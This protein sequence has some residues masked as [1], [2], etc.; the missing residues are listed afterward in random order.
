VSAFIYASI[1]TAAVPATILIP[2]VAA[3]D[4]LDPRAIARRFRSP[5]RTKRRW[6]R[7]HRRIMRDRARGAR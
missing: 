7:D 1:V 6:Q 2:P 3:F 4:V 5:A